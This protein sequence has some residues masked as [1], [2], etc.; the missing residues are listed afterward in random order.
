MPDGFEVFLSHAQEDFQLVY[1]VWGILYRLNVATYMHELYPNYRQDI[2]T[3]IRDV[4]KKCVMCIAFLTRYGINSQWVQQELGIAYAFG[5]V[6]VPVVEDE[7]EYKGFVQM[8]RQIPY[9]AQNPDEMIYQVIHAVRH[10]V[11]QRYDAVE[12]RLALT[13]P[14]DHENSYTLPSNPEIFHAINAGKVFV[15]KCLTCGA[16]M[17]VSPQTLEIVP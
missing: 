16:E 4:L 5:R 2:P 17:H 12:S 9:Q 8:I 10:H 13:C 11:M 7:V 6:I 15:I 1:R 14:S 3:G